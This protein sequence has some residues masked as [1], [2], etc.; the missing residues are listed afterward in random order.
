MK[1]LFVHKH[2]QS[3]IVE[4]YIN[5][6]KKIKEFKLYIIKFKEDDIIKPK[7]NLF[8]CKVNIK[9]R[10]PII[11]ITYYKCTFFANDDV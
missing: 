1:I 11:M 9:K 3:N 8:N 5:F 2:R 4:D 10:W 7:I 6:L